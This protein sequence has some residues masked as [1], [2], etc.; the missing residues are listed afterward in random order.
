MRYDFLKI[1][2]AIFLK[3]C[4][5]F[6]YPEKIFVVT[7]PEHYLNLDSF[8]TKGKQD[9]EYFV[10]AIQNLID[11]KNLIS[12]QSLYSTNPNAIGNSKL[13][14]K[15]LI[16]LSRQT[17]IPIFSY[18]SK[19]EINGLAKSI[20]DNNDNDN[21]VVV[22][23]LTKPMVKE[24]FKA[25]NLSFDEVTIEKNSINTLWIISFNENGTPYLDKDIKWLPYNPVPKK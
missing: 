12:I 7:P 5:L 6:A 21:K 20:I 10:S 15:M 4:F 13:P 11:D 8:T 25:L 23:A 18:F 1:F 19:F 2:I 3:Q 17:D 14:Y 22:V 9:T 16:P 24:F